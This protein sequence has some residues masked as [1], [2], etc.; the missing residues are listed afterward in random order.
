MTYLRWLNTKPDAERRQ[1]SGWC[2]DLN[3]AIP[4]LPARVPGR[5]WTTDNFHLQVGGRAGQAYIGE[6]DSAILIHYA[7]LWQCHGSR[8]PRSHD[9]RAPWAWG[10]GTKFQSSYQIFCPCPVHS[11]LQF[12]NFSILWMKRTLGEGG[13]LRLWNMRLHSSSR[14]CVAVRCAS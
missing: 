12:L 4:R 8:F 1:E 3:K 10:N 5:R 6:W 2:H 7:I 9:T 13:F 14:Q 11:Q